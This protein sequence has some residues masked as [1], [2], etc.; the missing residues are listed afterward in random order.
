MLANY[1]YAD[2]SGDYFITVDTDKCTGCGRCAEI[3]P[4]DIFEMVLDDYDET[5]PVVRNQITRELG[6]ECEAEICGYQ[7]HTVCE[8]DAIA[9]SW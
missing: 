7:C 9:H 4:K 2:A 6:H 3:C 8:V 5:V 1:G